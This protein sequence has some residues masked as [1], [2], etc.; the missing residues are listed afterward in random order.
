MIR[1]SIP[2][3]SVVDIVVWGAL[4]RSRQPG[5]LQQL[6]IYKEV[7]AR[8]I[9]VSKFKP[10]SHLCD[11]MFDLN[12]GIYLHEVVLV[13]LNNALKGR[14]VIQSRLIRSPGLAYTHGV[15]Q[16]LAEVLLD[17]FARFKIF[18]NRSLKQLF[19]E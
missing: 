4:A 5:T 7:V 6:G 2:E 19:G 11:P 14:Y 18:S 12:S 9:R 3:D 15:Q 16:G 13:S 1:T 8:F 17:D 10:I